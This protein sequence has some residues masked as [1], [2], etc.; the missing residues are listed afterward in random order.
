MRRALCTALLV[1]AAPGGTALAADAGGASAPG[2]TF[3]TARA[4]GVVVGS[5]AAPTA[6]LAAAA[7]G[8]EPRI[9]VRF[10]EQAAAFVVARVVVLRGSRVVATI[11]LGRVRTGRTLTV[12]WRRGRL[13]PGRYTVR[14]HARDRWSNQLRRS[15]AAPG[16]RTFV[17]PG[18]PSA[19]TT[20]VAPRPAGSGVFPVAGPHVYGEGLGA[21]RGNHRHQG[22]DLAAARGMPVVAP[23]AGTVLYT[24]YQ[25]G[26]AG[27]YVVMNASNGQAF[28]FAHCMQG[29]TAVSPGQAVGAGAQLCRVGSTGDSSGPHLHFEIWVG[30]WRIDKDSRFIDPLPQLRAWDH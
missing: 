21:D 14:V 16:K 4:G 10:V 28:F 3:P 25:R 18:T 7:R 11:R 24:D 12:P 8:G 22:Q 17:V 6:R 1:L 23:L 30:G 26:G 13:A 2:S 27:E 15:G 19:P 5:G 9:Q 20:P 29:S